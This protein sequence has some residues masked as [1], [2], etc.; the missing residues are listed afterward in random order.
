MP[1]RWLYRRSSDGV[2][3]TAEWGQ[4]GDTA[5]PGDYDGD[6]INDLAVR[7]ING[8][9]PEMWMNQ[10]AAG[11]QSF[12]WGGPTD[13]I[14][15]GDFDSD[16]KTDMAVIRNVNGSLY[17]W[18]ALS[19]HGYAVY[20]AGYHGSAATDFP[21]PSVDVDGS[22]EI[23]VWRDGMYSIL[24]IFTT[25]RGLTTFWWGQPGDFPLASYNLHYAADTPARY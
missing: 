13:T 21:V 23:A 19:S 5:A 25:W 11:I 20:D 18:V 4:Q 12:F 15:P 17:W 8:G 10:S 9:I 24:R 22:S 7:R 6:G 1:N 2:M 3:V 14:V 16:G